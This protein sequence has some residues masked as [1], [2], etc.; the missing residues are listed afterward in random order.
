MCTGGIPPL[1]DPLG[2]GIPQCPDGY[3]Y[4]PIS[5]LCC[6]NAVPPVNMQDPTIRKLVTGLADTEFD[7]AQAYKV[8]MQG[9]KDSGIIERIVVAFL[10]GAV[11]LLA[12]LIEEAASLLDDVLTVLAEA[13]QAAQG[14]NASGYYRLAGAL[15]TDLLGISTDGQALWQSF[16]S[17]GR[18]AAM[19]ALGGKIYDVLAA[20]FAGVAQTAADGTFNVQPGKGIGGLPDIQLTPEQGVNGGRAFLGFASAFAIR[21]G[22]TDMLAAYLPHGIGEVFKDFAEDFS[23]NLGIGRIGRLV[24]KNLVNVMVAQPMLWALN[25]QYGPKLFSA[26]EAY[27][28]FITGDFDQPALLE[29]LARMGYNAKRGAALQWQHLKAVD[30]R[31]LRTL[32]ATGALVDTDYDIWMRRNGHGPDVYSLMDQSDDLELLRGPVVSAA[33]HFAEQYLLG[34]ITRVQFTGSITAISKDL[35]GQALLT[36]GEVDALNRLPS[37]ATA[38]PRRHLG[39]IQL[40]RM[41]ED[42]LITLQNFSDEATAL[43]Y[44]PDDVQLLEQELLISAKRAEERAAKAA[45]AAQRG[46]FA[47]LTVAQMKT[48]YLEGLM[49]LDQVRAELAVRQYAASAIDA[50]ANE[51]LVAAGLKAKQPPTA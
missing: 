51:F 2:T 3:T 43:G 13:F 24:Y 30:P 7:P 20:E 17:G 29:E 37:I 39:V 31:M 6:P 11:K 19:V 1:P 47:K 25:K 34:K 22:N 9:V 10:R 46:M 48:A 44:A 28:A 38:A 18:Q 41:Y 42:G 12:P 23:K 26:G 35:Q 45:L 15:V 14:Q 27:R 8:G 21:E 32:H 50:V 33:R 49:T 40:F 5:N 4:D 16:T 36:V